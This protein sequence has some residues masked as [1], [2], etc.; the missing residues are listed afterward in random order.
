MHIL[1][2]SF[3]KKNGAVINQ[4][5]SILFSLSCMEFHCLPNFLFYLYE[6]YLCKV[7]TFSIILNTTSLD[8]LLADSTSSPIC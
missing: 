5:T 6:N 4:M 1:L 7:Q 8:Y 2:L 3:I